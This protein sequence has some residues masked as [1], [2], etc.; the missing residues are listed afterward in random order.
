MEAEESEA[1][2]QEESKSNDQFKMQLFDESRK[3]EYLYLVKLNRTAYAHCIWLD[4]ENA[5]ELS[6]N[7]LA[8]FVKKMSGYAQDV[9]SYERKFADLNS[10]VSE[11]LEPD[12]NSKPIYFNSNYLV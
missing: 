10:K 8:N 5:K 4:Y 2:E 3:K 11:N 7:K 6:K 12:S 9:K 1:G